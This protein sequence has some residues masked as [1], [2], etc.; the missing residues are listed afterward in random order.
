MKG[1]VL[2]YRVDGVEL[3]PLVMSL[4]LLRSAYPAGPPNVKLPSMGLHPF[5]TRDLARICSVRRAY[6]AAALSHK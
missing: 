5:K 2:R 1:I 3:P 6:P 4:L